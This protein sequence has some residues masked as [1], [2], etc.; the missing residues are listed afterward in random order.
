MARWFFVNAF[1][2]LS[3]AA[4]CSGSAGTA[5][6]GSVTAARPAA[7]K[8]GADSDAAPTTD[9]NEARKESS[10]IVTGSADT[11]AVVVPA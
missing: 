11:V 10:I 1:V 6:A 5:T 9:T 3:D 4:Q 2:R 8:H 7:L